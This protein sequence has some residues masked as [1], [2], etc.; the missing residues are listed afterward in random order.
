MDTPQEKIKKLF[1]SLSEALN[2]LSK[3]DERD[4]AITEIRVAQFWFDQHCDN[5]AAKVRKHVAGNRART[6]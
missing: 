2:E 1:A 6:S 5:I 3:T 4:E